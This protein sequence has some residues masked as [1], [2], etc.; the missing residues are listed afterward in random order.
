MTLNQGKKSRVIRTKTSPAFIDA[1]IILTENLNVEEFAFDLALISQLILV[2]L[3][4]ALL[5]DKVYFPFRI[6]AA[7]GTPLFNGHSS[8]RC[9]RGNH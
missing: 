4:V 7:D 8:C 3:F 2:L 9:S 5:H 1:L 6:L